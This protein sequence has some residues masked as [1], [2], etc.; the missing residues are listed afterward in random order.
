MDHCCDIGVRVNSVAQY[1]DPDA[2]GNRGAMRRQ[3]GGTRALDRRIVKES[4]RKN[5]F[6]KSVPNA[7]MES[8]TAS[9]AQKLISTK[10]LRRAR[11]SV[12]ESV[13]KISFPT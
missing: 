1:C 6:G 3:P 12:S 2:D 13:L 11:D 10:F 7:S 5:Q 8:K 9:Q 4:L